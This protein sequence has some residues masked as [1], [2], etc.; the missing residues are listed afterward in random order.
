MLFRR[1][2]YDRIGGHDAVKDDLLEDLAFARTLRR[3]GGRSEVLL[4]ENML[5]VSMYDTMEGFRI[6]WRRIFIDACK[7]RTRRLRKHGRRSLAAG[8]GLPAAQLAALAA[9]WA[10]F[11]IGHVEFGWIIV[12]AVLAGWVAQLIAL[13]II[14]PLSGTPR[15]N[16][17]FF[18]LGCC[19]VSLILFGAARRLEGREPIKLGG[20]EY[21]PE[22]R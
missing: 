7:R 17:C 1:D 11:R 8:V 18:P 9:A 4:A 20:R 6:G 21:V 14:Y 22:P 15:R 13:L 10:M 5:R 12:A 3:A 2:W 19:V 16:V